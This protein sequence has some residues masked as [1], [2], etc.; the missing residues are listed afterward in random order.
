MIGPAAEPFTS[1]LEEADTEH[2]MWKPL[3]GTDDR[4]QDRTRYQCK[5]GNRLVYV[6]VEPV[7]R[8]VHVQW[9]S[10]RRIVAECPNCGSIKRIA[11]GGPN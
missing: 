4:K 11:L 1:A 5:C 7:A 8:K 9:S 10:R 2:E 6:V 3:V